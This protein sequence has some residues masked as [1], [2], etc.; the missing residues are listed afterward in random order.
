M[1][2]WMLAGLGV[3]AFFAIW[4]IRDAELDDRRRKEKR[5]SRS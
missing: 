3:V 5:R 4:I 2:P 1:R